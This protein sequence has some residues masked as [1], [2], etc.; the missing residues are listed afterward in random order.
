M[1]ADY[2]PDSGG[3]EGMCCDCAHGGPCCDFSENPGC[4]FWKQDGSCWEALTKREKEGNTMEYYMV[5]VGRKRKNMEWPEVLYVQEDCQDSGAPILAESLVKAK[6]FDS[7]DAA[8]E[9]VEVLY[10]GRQDENETYVIDRV[11]D[12]GPSRLAISHI[13]P[14]RKKDEVKM[15]LPSYEPADG[16]GVHT[17][18]YTFMKGKFCGSVAFKVGGNGKGGC[19]LDTD[20]LSMDTQ[21]DIDRYVENTCQFAYNE[22]TGEYSAVLTDLE[23][24]PLK[25]VGGEEEFGEMLVAAEI[26][27]YEPDTG[28]GE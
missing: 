21:E 25:V 10:A 3:M 13:S 12:E 24:N 8:M 16:S 6:K 1:S 2:M 9:V 14:E 7:R 15:P 5:T 4:P 19:L 26:V 11:T 18:R 22:E 28:G 17:I 23:G 20:F 27:C